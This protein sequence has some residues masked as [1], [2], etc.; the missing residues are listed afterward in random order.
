MLT[1]KYRVWLT[2]VHK[3]E[4][5]S[6][7]GAH[8]ST[9]KSWPLLMLISKATVFYGENLGGKSDVVTIKEAQ[10]SDS[11]SMLVVATIGKYH[12]SS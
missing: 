8:H 1:H 12:V 3:R 5:L 9:R 7:L 4:R 6:R 10:L 2:P 11:K